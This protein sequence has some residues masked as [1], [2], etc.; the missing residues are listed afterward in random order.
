[1]QM[2]TVVSVRVGSFS[3]MFPN[4]WIRDQEVPVCTR[5][6]LKRWLSWELQVAKLSLWKIHCK[7]LIMSQE[8]SEPHERDPEIIA[9]ARPEGRQAS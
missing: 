1:M 2:F 3:Q 7:R 4:T 5:S 6:V 8:Q 9:P